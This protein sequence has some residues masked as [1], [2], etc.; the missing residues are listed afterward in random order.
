MDSCEQKI[1]DALYEILMQDTEDVLF[2]YYVKEDR[3][4]ANHSVLCRS[5]EEARPVEISICLWRARS[6]P[7][8]RRFMRIYPICQME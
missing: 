3:Y 1:K 5:R 4:V 7:D 2:R 8:Y 6:I